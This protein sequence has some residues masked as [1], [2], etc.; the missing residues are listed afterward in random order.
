MRETVKKTKQ[1]MDK[2]IEVLRD[3]LRTL[4]TGRASIAILDP[5]RVDYF[6]TP[7]PLNQVANL[8]VPDASLLLIQPWDPTLIPAIEHA[9]Q[10]ANL[11]LNP[12]NDGKIIKLPVPAPTQER[13]KELV[14]VAHEY[15]ERARTAVRN[16]RREA[17]DE[18]KAMEKGKKISEDDMH[19]G[20]EEVQKLTDEH[21]E[22]INKA[23]AA[24]EKEILEV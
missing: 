16:V 10:K 2:A 22:E 5:I 23:L 9:I 12:M 17:N 24:R 4:R 7:T 14:K 21:V 19:R 20:F 15:A 3:E 18:L 1:R 13:R 8:G 11:G 6:G